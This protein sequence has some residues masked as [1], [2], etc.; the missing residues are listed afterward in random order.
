MPVG[1]AAAANAPA[2]PTAAAPAEEKKGKYMFYFSKIIE[3]L[4]VFIF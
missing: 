4:T 1:G 3:T 2:V